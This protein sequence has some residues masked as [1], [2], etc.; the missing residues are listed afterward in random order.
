MSK[1]IRVTAILS[2]IAE[3]LYFLLGQL[4]GTVLGLINFTPK[5]LLS[6]NN[7]GELTTSVILLAVTIMGA[8]VYSIVVAGLDVYLL[9]TARSESENVILEIIGLVYIG[10]LAPLGSLLSVLINVIAA[11]F[12][13]QMGL[14]LV[15]SA[16]SMVGYFGVLSSIATTLLII[17]LSFSIFRKKYASI[18]VYPEE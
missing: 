9:A 6:G 7:S 15:S 2:L 13:G 4:L 5:G 3:V 17:S 12:T 11:H 8:A 18:E 1:A 14:V 16:R 10:V